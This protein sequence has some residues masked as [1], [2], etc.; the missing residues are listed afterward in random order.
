[1]YTG[2]PEIDG[3]SHPEFS[4]KRTVLI[5][6]WVPSSV[7]SAEL[8]EFIVEAL[9]HWGGQRRADNHLFR[10]LQDVEVIFKPTITIRGVK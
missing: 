4:M 5:Q 9:S 10:S 1:M 8:R 3:R 7:G 6:F 2:G